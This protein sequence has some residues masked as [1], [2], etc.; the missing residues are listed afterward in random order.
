MQ[1]FFACCLIVR[2]AQRFA[3]NR[4]HSFDRLADPLHPS[5]ETR[6]TLFGINEGKHAPE[7]LVRRNSIGQVEQIREKS[8]FRVPTFLDLNPSF[9]STYD[10]TDRQNDDI[11]SSM[12]LGSLHPRVFHLRKQAFQISSVVLLHLLASRFFGLFY[13]LLF[14]SFIAVEFI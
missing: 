4:D 12:P 2:A 13:H 7:R 3:I 8:L 10:S 6:F 11:P 9:C 14:L 1:R 5:D